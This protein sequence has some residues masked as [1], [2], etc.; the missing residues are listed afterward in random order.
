[1]PLRDLHCPECREVEEDV[2]CRSELD[3]RCDVCG[4]TRVRLFTPA[5]MIGP[6]ERHPRDLTKASGM[7][8]TSAAA[9]RN[10]FKRTPNA[11]LVSKSDSAYQG[12]YTRT[13]DA[14]EI[15]AKKQGYR[16]WDHRQHATPAE[17]RERGSA[18]EAAKKARETP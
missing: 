8:F 10:Y 11:Q 3:E 9:E 2:I 5:A 4:A 12:M 7:M 13:R 18:I 6:T 1:M 17:K 16:D 15:V 14:N